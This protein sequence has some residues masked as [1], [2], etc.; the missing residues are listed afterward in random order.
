MKSDVEAAYDQGCADGKAEKDAALA[1]LANELGKYAVAL[2]LSR[3][4]GTPLYA[5]CNEGG[6]NNPLLAPDAGQQAAA[7]YRQALAVVER[8]RGTLAMFEQ[9]NSEPAVT[10]LLRDLLAEEKP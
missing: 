5:T 6:C 7:R 10:E 8:V 1:V 2:H 9:I 3:G 4:H